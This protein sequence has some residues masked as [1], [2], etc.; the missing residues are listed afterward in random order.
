MLI[1]DKPLLS[2]QQLPFPQGWSLDRETTVYSFSEFVGNVF[3]EEDSKIKK[4][5]IP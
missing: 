3:G 5:L 1:S 2:G 4:L